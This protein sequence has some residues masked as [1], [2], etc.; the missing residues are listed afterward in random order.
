M[1]RGIDLKHLI[2]RK[3]NILQIMGFTQSCGVGVGVGVGVAQSR[4][5]WLES[6]FKTAMESE[7][8]KMPESNKNINYLCTLLGQN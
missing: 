5:F 7:S 4:R 1:L 2:L 8:E 6:E 3:K